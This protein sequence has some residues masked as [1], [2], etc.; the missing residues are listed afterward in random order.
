MALAAS[1]DEDESAS[2]SS[3]AEA[4]EVPNLLLYA[5]IQIRVMNLILDSDLIFFLCQPYIWEICI[6]HCRI[7]WRKP[8]EVVNQEERGGA[9]KYPPPHA[10]RHQHHHNATI[11]VE[12]WNNFPW[13]SD[14]VSVSALL[15]NQLDPNGWVWDWDCGPIPFCRPISIRPTSMGLRLRSVF[16]Q[17]FSF[18]RP[19][20]SLYLDS[21]FLCIPNYIIPNS[22]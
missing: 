22:F 9:P 12:S 4:L 19:H 14:G 21:C 6:G 7:D 15:N 13:S 8:E 11:T 10:S 16:T 2:S 17:L 1:D 3:I 5:A 20:W 18:L